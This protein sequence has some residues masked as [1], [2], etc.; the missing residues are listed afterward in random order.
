MA[1]PVTTLNPDTLWSP[2]SHLGQIYAHGAQVTAGARL[3]F[4]SGQFGVAPDGSLPDGFEAQA[5]TA[6]ANVERMLTA[7][8]MN[9]ANLAKLTFF[10]TRADDGP[11]L[12]QARQRRWGSD[13]PPAVTVITVSALA[14]PE[15]L[16]E[17]EAVAAA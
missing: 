1:Q 10:L 13:A 15:Y 2:P 6:M 4:V 8:G 5:D 14:R 16:I 9:F 11:T 12:S 7:A 17:I 3:L